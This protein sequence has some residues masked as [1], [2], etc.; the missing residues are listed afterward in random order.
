MHTHLYSADDAQG[1]PERLDDTIS[2]SWE[3][4]KLFLTKR[5]T[6]TKPDSDSNTDV[7]M[8]LLVATRTHQMLPV[9]ALLPLIFASVLKR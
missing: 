6:G 9:Q 3:E 8:S 5:S 4:F 2:E 1:I 7:V